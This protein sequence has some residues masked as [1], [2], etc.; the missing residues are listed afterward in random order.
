MSIE[1]GEF[2]CSIHE[3]NTGSVQQWDEHCHT[4]G[5]T[6]TVSQICED[7]GVTNVKDIPYPKGYVEKAHSGRFSPVRV[8][9][10]VCCKLVGGEGA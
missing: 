10:P 8:E 7:C 1:G 4:A 5:H 9:C 3:F 6:L 2:K